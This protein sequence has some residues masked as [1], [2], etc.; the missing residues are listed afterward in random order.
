MISFTYLLAYG[1]ILSLVL[2]SYHR[3]YYLLRIPEKSIK[4]TL[5]QISR[6]I[7][8][9][10]LHNEVLCACIA[11]V[12]NIFNTVYMQQGFELDFV[13]LGCVVWQV[14]VDFALNLMM[15]N[16]SLNAGTNQANSRP[17]RVLTRR[18][19]IESQRS[20]LRRKLVAWFASM[21]VV[22]IVNVTLYTLASTIW[23]DYFYELSAIIA[24]AIV[25]YVV[26]N[27]HLLDLFRDG[28]LSHEN[29]P[30]PTGLSQVL[31]ILAR[32]IGRKPSQVLPARV[33]Q[34][35]EV[36]PFSG[37]QE[38]VSNIESSVASSSVP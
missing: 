15:L 21:L 3:F 29:N 13:I 36:N 17:T 19:R 20:R 32:A 30:T 23:N 22:N 37:R 9:K 34:L 28:V 2:A 31:Q 8:G 5:Y 10:R 24:S 25:L 33:T 4:S 27:L 11:C 35:S 1:S 16:H 18:E 38:A 7:T 6:L 26:I 14:I 12:S